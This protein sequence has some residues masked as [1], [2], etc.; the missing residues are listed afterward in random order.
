MLLMFIHIVC[1]SHTCLAEAHGWPLGSLGERTAW[2]EEMCS[3][4]FSEIERPS[5]W[6]SSENPWP[7]SCSTPLGLWTIRK[8]FPFTRCDCKLAMCR[9]S[10]HCSFLGPRNIMG[11]SEISSHFAMTTIDY[12]ARIP[13]NTSMQTALRFA[14]YKRS[15]KYAVTWSKQPCQDTAEGWRTAV[16]EAKEQASIEFFRKH[17]NFGLGQDDM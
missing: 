8:A 7:E 11:S 6:T 10:V 14:A 5:L 17:T 16:R 15:L 1:W 9:Y 4:P 2:A 3:S 12:I 13:I